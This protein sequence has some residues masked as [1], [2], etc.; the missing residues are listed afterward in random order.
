MTER[1]DSA[2]VS[3]WIDI[4][5]PLNKDLPVLP[6]GVSESPVPPPK[7]E[8]FF[9][10]DRGDKVTMSRIEISSHDGTHIDAPLH[11]FYGGVTIDQMPMDTTV[12]P[13]RIIEIKDIESIKPEELEATIYSPVSVFSLKPGIR[14]VFIT[15]KS[16]QLSPYTSLRRQPNFWSGRRCGLSELTISPSVV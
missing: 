10:V 11:F 15:L 2:P 3:E 13:A 1:K 14:R 4:T 7:V 5:L 12:G 8:R 16:F 6:G 9:D